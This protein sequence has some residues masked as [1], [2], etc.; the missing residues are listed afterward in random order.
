MS[1]ISGSSLD[2]VIELPALCVERIRNR[3]TARCGEVCGRELPC[4]NHSVHVG[5]V[6]AGYVAAFLEEL[7]AVRD[8]GE[9]GSRLGGGK[10]ALAA[11]LAASGH[12]TLTGAERMIWSV[13]AGD[14]VAVGN[15]LLDR[16]LTALDMTDRWTRPPFLEAADREIAA[17]GPMPPDPS[18]PPVESGRVEPVVP[19]LRVCEDCGGEVEPGVEPIGLFR[20][21]PG[22]PRGKNARPGGR[23]WREWV[24][25]RRCRGEAL[26]RRAMSGTVMEAGVKRTLRTR[27]RVAPK[28]GGRPRLMS[29]AELRVTHLLYEK[30]KLSV[31]AV[32]QL[33][34]EQR[35]AGTVGGYASAL[36]YGWKRLGLATRPRGVAMAMSRFGTDGTKTK[37]QKRRCVAAVKRGVRRGKRCRQWAMKGRRFCVDHR[38]LEV[39]GR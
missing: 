14:R 16:V 36:H 1:A 6:A 18:L 39:I 26:R 19:V 35:P 20:P 13:R 5:Q 21:I 8:R 11:E 4:P 2:A 33:L 17:A 38:A 37:P 22:A 12:F 28:K 32:A 34:A 27:E 25:C 10:G 29:D 23:R 30:R 15:E 3:K 31:L 7:I 24:L 9:L